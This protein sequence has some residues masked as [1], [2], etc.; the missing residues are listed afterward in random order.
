VNFK[1]VLIIAFAAIVL[2]GGYKFLTRVNK[3]DPVAVGTAF[4]KALRAR[5]TSAAS[6]YFMPD[7]AQAWQAAVDENVRKMR[8]APAERFFEAIPEAPAFAS[9]PGKAPTNVTLRSADNSFTLEMTQS[10][11]NWYVSK[12]PI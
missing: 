12:A 8:S 10:A 3:S 2:I 4:T 7:R 5:D 6:H 1:K 9:V 11:G